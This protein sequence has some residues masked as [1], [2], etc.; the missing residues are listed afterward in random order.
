M[1]AATVSA[2]SSTGGTTEPSGRRRLP[3]AVVS[4]LLAIALS[5]IGLVALVAPAT[6]ASLTEVGPVDKHDRLSLLAVTPRSASTRSAWSSAWTTSRTRCVP[7]WATDRVRGSRSRCRRTSPTSRSGGRGRRRS[8]RQPASR[9]DSCSARR[10][11][12]AASGTSPLVSR[13]RSRGCASA[14]TT[15]HR[16]R[17]PRDHA[18]RRSRRRGREHVVVLLELHHHAASHG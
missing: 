17:L 7:S 3:S 2:I 13:W 14:S 9:R 10:L 16:G 12:S 5:G 1:G 15:C 6:A 18:V 11:P 8:R 4:G